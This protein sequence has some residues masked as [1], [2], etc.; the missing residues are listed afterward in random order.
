M[1]AVIWTP[2]IAALPEM[3][4]GNGVSSVGSS[5]PTAP[6]AAALLNRTT[7]PQRRAV[8]SSFHQR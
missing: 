3:P 7:E 2:G 4:A 5:T 8:S 1:V 6:A